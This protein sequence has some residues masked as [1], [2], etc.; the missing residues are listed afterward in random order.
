M[1]DHIVSA[2]NEQSAVTDDVARNMEQMS[3][4]IEEN[5][6]S[7]THVGQAVEELA[8]RAE[9]LHMLVTHFDAMA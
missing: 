5:N 1:A 9:E 6:K 7:I 2:A 8:S 3:V 4:L